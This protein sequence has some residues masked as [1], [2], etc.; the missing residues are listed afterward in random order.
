MEDRVYPDGSPWIYST[1]SYGLS[2]QRL[3]TGSNGSISTSV[4]MFVHPDTI[5]QASSN[6][7]ARKLLAQYVSAAG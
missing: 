5:T 2:M 1:F 6:V 7:Y 4:G 3:G